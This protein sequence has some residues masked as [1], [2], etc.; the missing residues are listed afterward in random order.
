[1]TLGVSWWNR[2]P[3]HLFWNIGMPWCT[4]SSPW[5]KMTST[6]F[7]RPTTPKRTKKIMP[8]AYHLENPICCSQC[9]NIMVYEFSLHSPQQTIRKLKVMSAWKAIHIFFVT[10]H[11]GHILTGGLSRYHHSVDETVLEDLEEYVSREHACGLPQ[12]IRSIFSRLTQIEGLNYP[13]VDS[14][15]ATQLFKKL[16]SHAP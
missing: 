16:S 9:L 1:M 11:I 7:A 15:Q 2:L 6:I 10:I 8:L 13:P 5:S 14:A 12:G 3:F 4:V